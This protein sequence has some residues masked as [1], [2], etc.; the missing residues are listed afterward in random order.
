MCVGISGKVVSIDKGTAVID[1]SGAKREVSVDLIE[2]LEP[3]DYVMVHAGTA[4]AKITDTDDHET[5]TIMGKL[6]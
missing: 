4:I 5:N 3:G 2:D 1:M 6:S